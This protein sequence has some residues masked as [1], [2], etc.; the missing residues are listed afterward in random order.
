LPFALKYACPPAIG[1]NEFHIVLEKN[2][3]APHNIE[4]RRAEI[5]KL[6]DLIEKPQGLLD[7][8]NFFDKF[9]KIYFYGAAYRA[10]YVLDHIGFEYASKAAGLACSD[11]FPKEDF[12]LPVFHLS[13][14]LFLTSENIGIVC[15]LSDEGK[16]EVIPKLR[17]LGF[18][19]ILEQ[20]YID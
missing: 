19:N 6:N 7:L 10:R 1:D 8:R 17:E 5:A 14:L 2:A 16:T 20:A 9:S 11:H 4:L 3:N 18:N 13:E 12:P 15:V